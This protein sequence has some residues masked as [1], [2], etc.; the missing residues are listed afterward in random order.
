M[1]NNPI[2]VLRMLRADRLRREAREARHLHHNLRHVVVQPKD[3]DETANGP[4]PFD[5]DTAVFVVCA[6]GAVVVFWASV[7][8]CPSPPPRRG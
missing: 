8:G 7:L 1:N 5:G 6:V 4:R 2:R 3:Y